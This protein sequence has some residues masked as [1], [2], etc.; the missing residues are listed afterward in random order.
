MKYKK[1]P[2]AHICFYLIFLKINCELSWSGLTWLFWIMY[3]LFNKFCKRVNP[4]CLYNNVIFVLWCSIW[5]YTWSSLWWY[6]WLEK[7]FWKKIQ[8]S[9]K[10]CSVTFC[11]STIVIYPIVNPTSIQYI[12]SLRNT[13]C[14]GTVS[15]VLWKLIR[16]IFYSIVKC[17][18]NILHYII[19]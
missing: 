3:S 9:M 6:V 11:W 2:P 8:F 12:F 10:Q 15:N 5:C 19:Y 17:L 13:F 4:V 7:N 16:I 1:L 18:F 14:W